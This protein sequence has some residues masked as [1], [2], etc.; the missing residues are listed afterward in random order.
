MGAMARRVDKGAAIGRDFN[1]FL[2]HLAVFGDA[3]DSEKIAAEAA[4]YEGNG[5]AADEGIENQA[6]LGAAG[7]DAG[8]DKRFRED[9]EVG[10]AE[11][12]EGD[13]PNG[14]FVAAERMKRLVP[15]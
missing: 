11:F 9:G 7:E 3:V 13:R 8:F 10:V 2:R 6:A 12:G 1:S 14:A 4:S 15:A 5:A